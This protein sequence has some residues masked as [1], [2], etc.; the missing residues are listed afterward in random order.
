VQVLRSDGIRLTFVPEQFAEATLSGNS[1][2][3]GACR[4]AMKQIDQ[5]LIGSVIEQAASQLAYQKWKM[6]NA[7]DPKFVQAGDSAGGESAGTESILVGKPAPVFE[8]DL[9]QGGRFKLAEMKDKVVVLDFWATW[10][11]PCRASI[12]HLQQLQ[13]RYPDL[14]VVGVSTEEASDIRDFATSAQLTYPVAR[15]SDGSMWRR[16]LA[17]AIP[18]LVIIDRAGTVRDIA[19]GL[20]D[21]AALDRELVAL[22][23]RK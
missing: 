17:D 12:P 18:M 15:D 22:M 5:L 16:Y 1:E 13:A 4:V 11:G 8:L 14:R 10:C 2:V 23:T 3:L 6:Q 9:L 19:I 21:P 7:V 20:S